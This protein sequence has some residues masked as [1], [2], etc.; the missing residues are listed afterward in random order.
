MKSTRPRTIIG[1][2]KAAQMAQANLEDHIAYCADLRNKLWEKIQANIPNVNV[3]GSLDKRHPGNLSVSF[4]YI[5][6][7]AILLMLDAFG[8]CVSTGSACSSGSLASSQV[9]EA[10]G[11][12]VTKMNGTVRFTV[13]DFTTEEDIDYVVDALTKVVTRLRELSPVTGKEGW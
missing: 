12:P 8:I 9:L 10:I 2:G 5:E 7:E 3:N 6:G 13:G 11:V 4:D 1:F